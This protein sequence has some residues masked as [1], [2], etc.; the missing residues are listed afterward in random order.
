MSI[1]TIT[2]TCVLIFLLLTVLDVAG[3]ESIFKA[4]SVQVSSRACFECE[5][6]QDDVNFDGCT[7][8]PW[9]A[10]G[11]TLCKPWQ[12]FCYKYNELEFCKEINSTHVKYIRRGCSGNLLHKFCIPFLMDCN[13]YTCYGDYCNAAFRS[14]GG[15]F[16][17]L[18]VGGGLLRLLIDHLWS[19]T[20]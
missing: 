15:G 17:I 2:S 19:W 1:L 16:F 3:G 10:A 18:L 11:I 8:E 14:S 7:A 4:S 5:A 9:K 12:V 20:I 13:S 6:K